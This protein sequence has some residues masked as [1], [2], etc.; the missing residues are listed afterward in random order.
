LY[1]ISHIFTMLRNYE[2]NPDSL[3]NRFNT[4]ESKAFDA[5]FRQH[6]KSLCFFVIG[7]GVER[8]AA[9]DIVED[10]F[11]KAW[12]KREDFPSIQ[13]L[14]S[15]LYT[16]TRNTTLNFLRDKNR[17]QLKEREIQLLSN[18][19]IDDFSHQVI[20]AEAI[21][22]VLQAIEKLPPLYRQIIE[23]F[24]INERDYKQIATE[25]GRPVNTIRIQRA[26]AIILLRK[27]LPHL[28]LLLSLIQFAPPE[29]HENI[30]SPQKTAEQIVSSYY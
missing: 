11:I 13:S 24:Y 7:Y 8:M 20:R 14:R 26:R 15:F 22:E 3:I 17:H 16:V 30:N 2:N 19:Y 21:R 1:V 6:F 28:V 25:L 12:D 9:E 4:G 27:Q 23:M 18:S 5:L 29:V 10:A